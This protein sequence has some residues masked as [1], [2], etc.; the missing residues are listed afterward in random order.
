MR[1]EQ[2]RALYDSLL[3]HIQKEIPGFRVDFKDTTENKKLR[4]TGA[5]VGLFNKAYM[6][7]FTTT[8][9][10]V[11]YFSS[12]EKV[13]SDPWGAFRILAH[14]YVHLCDEKVSR[15][16]FPVGY[17]MPQILAVFSLGAVGAI[18][19]SWFLLFLVFLLALAPWPSPWRSHREMRGY[20]MNMALD[21]WISGGVPQ[22]RKDAVLKTF[23]GWGYYKMWPNKEKVRKEIERRSEII[24]SGQIHSEFA[25]PHPFESVRLL[26][27]SHGV[28]H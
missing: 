22:W 5:V 13:E 12:K 1:D 4:L 9:Y 15:F 24:V 18:W 19:S 2:G 28:D 11:V 3:E 8:L 23:T 6:T 7:R 26:V 16:G 14:E 17:L 21:C 27:V 20:S 25:N 10:P